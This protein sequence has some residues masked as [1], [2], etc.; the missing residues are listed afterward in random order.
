[1]VMDYNFQTN[2]DFEFTN[3]YLEGVVDS[4]YTIDETKRI[5]QGVQVATRYHSGQDRSDGNAFIVHPMRVSLLLHKYEKPTTAD[6]FIAALLHDALEDTKLTE[7]EVNDLFGKTVLTYVLGVTRYRPE[8]QTAE[9][10][11]QGKAEKWQKIMQ[12]SQEIR[13]IKTFDYLDNVISMKFIPPNMP[14]FQKIPRWLMETKTMY[15]PLAKVTNAEAYK[16]LKL[17]FNYYIRKG[18]Q[19]GTWES[20]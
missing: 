9:F 7:G 14:H 8:E 19:V 1:M 6:M 4:S 17:E 3:A 18:F 16:L 11:K 20:G 2:H 15:L 10:R 5:I 12:S 13:A